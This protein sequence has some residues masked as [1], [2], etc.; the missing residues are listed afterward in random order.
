VLGDTPERDYAEKLASF[1]RFAA[2]E[3]EAIVAGL[4]LGGG[5]RVLDLGCGA[6]WASRL[7]SG[8][9][10]RVVAMDL[11][12]AHARAAARRGAKVD[13]LVAD[14]A[15]LPFPSRV[16]DGAWACNTV[17]HVDRP[18]EVLR[19]LR[20]RVRSGGVVALAQSALTPE[21]FFPWN[22]HF[23]ARLRGACHRFYRER[24]GLA[25]GDTAAMPRLVGMMRDASFSEVTVRTHV[26][27]R[28]APLSTTDRAY[29]MGVVDGYW[30][31]KVEPFLDEADRL[32]LARWCDPA[33][34]EFWLDRG[35]FHH[36]QTLTV[37]RGRA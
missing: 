13:V 5:Q 20:G 10:C 7:L 28:T 25:E 12:W 1:E 36:V 35:D 17:H 26:I 11:S 8:L 3:L 16:F 2:P 29:F 9:G 34:S 30:G 31:R 6:G 21:L 22:Y 15:R 32:R 24:Y 4:G 37:V 19:E 14:A 18:L 27:E 33:S 23:D